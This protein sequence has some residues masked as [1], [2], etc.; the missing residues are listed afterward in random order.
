MKKLIEV[1]QKAYISRMFRA[2]AVN[3]TGFT[4]FIYKIVSLFIDPVTR[5]KIKLFTS[6]HPKKLLKYVDKD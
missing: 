3:V 5:I 6:W 1:F 4:L 2:L